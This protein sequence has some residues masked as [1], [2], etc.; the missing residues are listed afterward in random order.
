MRAHNTIFTHQLDPGAH[1]PRQSISPSHHSQSQPRPLV[2]LQMTSGL[3]P[4]L[5]RAIR[6]K[7]H[8]VH[9][10]QT[11]GNVTQ[12]LTKSQR[13]APSGVILTVPFSELMSVPLYV[14]S[15]SISSV[16]R[17]GNSGRQVVKER[18]LETRRST[19]RTWT[20]SEKEDADKRVLGG[21]WERVTWRR[22]S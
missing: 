6:N 16:G 1:A 14:V 7:T 4:P 9:K 19:E 3:R 18:I 10:P 8:S 13:T 12:T 21:M 2:C 5:P 20:A 15:P 22:V 17:F 11:E